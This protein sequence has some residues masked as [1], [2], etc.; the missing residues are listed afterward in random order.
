MSLFV[1]SSVWF[2]A[3][4]S[5]DAHNARA[6][7]LLATDEAL[8]TTDHIVLETWFLLR[9]RIHRNAAEAYWAAMRTG[10]AAI[11]LVGLADLEAAW[12]IGLAFP[13]QDFSLVDRT[14][15]AVM[16]RLGIERAASFDN[17]FAVFRYG[18]QQRRAFE[19]VR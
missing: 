12:Q 17:H 2:A 6:K 9:N 15:F 16:Q 10:I 18:P 5:S 19:I 4:D 3:I 8:L 7:G 11:E 13:D 14:T 1:D